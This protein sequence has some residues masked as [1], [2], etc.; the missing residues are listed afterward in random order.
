MDMNFFG[1]LFGNGLQGNKRVHQR[2]RKYVVKEIKQ[3][4][5]FERHEE[6]YVDE[7]GFPEKTE[8][9][10]IHQADCGHIVHSSQELA[11]RCVKCGSYLCHICANALRCKRCL[12]LLCSS[13]AKLVGSEVYCS[14][15]RAIVYLRRAGIFSL[16]GIHNIFSKEIS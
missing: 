1:S 11:G 16:K 4:E 3:D 7:L 13:C 12:E 14:R 5:L 8:K 9:A 2:N 10:V 15:C 6:T